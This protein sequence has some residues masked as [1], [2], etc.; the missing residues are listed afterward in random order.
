MVMNKAKYFSFREIV[1]CQATL[2]TWQRPELAHVLEDW[3]QFP[4]EAFSYC[5]S[6]YKRLNQCGVA[7]NGYGRNL[8]DKPQLNRINLKI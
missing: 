5:H 7:R 4:E 6:S 3:A 1:R 2:N 8:C